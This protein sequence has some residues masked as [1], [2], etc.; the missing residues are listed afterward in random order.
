MSAVVPPP[1]VF[2]GATTEAI[3]SFVRNIGIPVRAASLPD[4][5]PFPGLAISRGAVLVD[6]STLIQ[7]G[8]ILHEAG[9]IAVTEASRRGDENVGYTNGQELSALAW[10]YAACIDLGLL[11]ETVF[12]PGSYQGWAESLLEGFGEGRYVGHW[13]LQVWGM[14]VEPGRAQRL[15]VAGYP[16]MIRWLR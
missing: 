4:A 3:A 1:T 6:E 16:A 8:D 2:R 5:R 10:S 11:P 15:G 12:Y 13:M 14:C 7:P 9:H